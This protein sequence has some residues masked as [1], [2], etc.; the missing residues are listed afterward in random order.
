MGM[1]D[2][3]Y[4]PSTA[5]FFSDDLAPRALHFFSQQNFTHKNE[6]DELRAQAGRRRDP[7]RRRPIARRERER[8]RLPSLSTAEKKQR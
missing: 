6:H 3:K 4:F 2:P 5:P 7:G 8:A 1:S